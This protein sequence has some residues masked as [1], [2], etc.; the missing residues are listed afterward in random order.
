V[1]F[2]YDPLAKRE[3]IVLHET[4]HVRDNAQD[5]AT[6]EL[7]AAARVVAAV[8]QPSRPSTAPDTGRSCEVRVTVGAPCLPLIFKFKE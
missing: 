1:A 3:L 7:A 4:T 5:C 2:Q 8:P 6:S